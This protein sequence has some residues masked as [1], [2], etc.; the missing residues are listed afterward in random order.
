[1]SRR[2]VL[3]P[4]YHATHYRLNDGNRKGSA[5]NGWHLTA[6]QLIAADLNV[7]QHDT[8][9]KRVNGFRHRGSSHEE[10]CDQYSEMKWDV[11]TIA[12]VSF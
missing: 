10:P 5:A 11:L 2:T 7:R 3:K 1:M 12:V 6:K 8:S 4:H 9:I